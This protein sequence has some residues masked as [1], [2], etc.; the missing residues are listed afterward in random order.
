MVS[1]VAGFRPDMVSSSPDEVKEAGNPKVVGSV[2]DKVADDVDTVDDVVKKVKEPIVESKAV[3]SMPEKVVDEV[4]TV[5]KVVEK[6]KKSVVESKP[7]EAVPDKVAKKVDTVEEVVDKKSQSSKNGYVVMENQHTYEQMAASVSNTKTLQ[8]G[9]R[10]KILCMK[11]H[12]PITM[13][14]MD[15]QREPFKK[16]KTS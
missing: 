13:S 10:I 5:N 4:K 11:C 7:V 8:H 15:E 6:V 14:Q 16:S 2:A 12:L 9:A 3:E 1:S